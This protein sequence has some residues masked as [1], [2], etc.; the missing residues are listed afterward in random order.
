V[1]SFSETPKQGMQETK[2]D[3]PDLSFFIPRK[4]FSSRFFLDWWVIFPYSFFSLIL[5]LDGA[6]HLTLIVY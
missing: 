3:D 6:D 4:D 5:S 1:N 2:E